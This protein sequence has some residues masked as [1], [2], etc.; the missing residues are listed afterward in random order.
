MPSLWEDPGFVLIEAAFCRANIISSN[1]HNGAIDFFDNK[2]LGYVFDL[3][4]KNQFLKL[5]EVALNDAE[6][7]NKNNKNILFKRTR[8]YSV[9]RHFQKLNRLLYL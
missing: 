7:K 5:L 4:N 1:C 8:D 2:R 6:L 3:N 9:F